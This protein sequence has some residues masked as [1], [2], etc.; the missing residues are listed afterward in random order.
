MPAPPLSAS[1]NRSAPQYEEL[2]I[3]SFQHM[4]QST[5]PA[6]TG[7]T[8]L[9]KTPGYAVPAIAPGD[10]SDRAIVSMTISNI[11]TETIEIHSDEVTDGAAVPP[12]FPLAPG[13][14]YPFT[15]DRLDATKIRNTSAANPAIVAFHFLAYDR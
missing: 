11:G 5:L 6:G 3:P 15:I 2:R 8:P 1:N 13:A 7:W 9:S 4:W 14:T 12:G 10:K